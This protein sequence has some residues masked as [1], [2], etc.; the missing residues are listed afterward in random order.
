[1]RADR[2]K[3]LSATAHSVAF[4]PRSC[5]LGSYT[6]QP[7]L[8]PHPPPPGQ[9]GTPWNPSQ[10]L[11]A[12]PRSPVQHLFDEPPYKSR[13]G[14]GPG[15]L[16]ELLRTPSAAEVHAFLR[17]PFTP[18]IAVPPVCT[19]AA[20]AA[21][22]AASAGHVHDICPPLGSPVEECITPRRDDQEATGLR[23]AQLVITSDS[24]QS[25]YQRVSLVS[26]SVCLCL[27]L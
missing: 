7:D 22:A 13:H 10:P 27:S 21:R 6:A 23:G 17:S 11:P 9:P 19:A 20:T 15:P 2:L 5:Q 26:L 1:M 25:D 4:E 24:V 12:K 14:W 16:A 8:F 18:H 3:A